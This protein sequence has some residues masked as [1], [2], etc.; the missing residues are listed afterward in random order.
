MTQKI[1][2]IFQGSV[3]KNSKD[4]QAGRENAFNHVGDL[5]KQ[6]TYIGSSDLKAIISMI[7]S[8]K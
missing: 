4:Y 3:D 2:K 1:F 8:L 6:F 5:L 7:R